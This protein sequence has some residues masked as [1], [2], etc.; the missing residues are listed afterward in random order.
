MS[1]REEILK[2]IMYKDPDLYRKLKRNVNNLNYPFI[3]A[4]HIFKNNVDL[5][6]DIFSF[7][8][9]CEI[10]NKYKQTRLDARH[11]SIPKRSEFY[12]KEAMKKGEFEEKILK[13]NVC[14]YIANQILDNLIYNPLFKNFMT[15][16]IKVKGVEYE[17]EFIFVDTQNFISKMKTYNNNNKDLK[18]L[19]EICDSN[20]KFNDKLEEIAKVL[21]VRYNPQFYKIL[22]TGGSG[23]EIILGD[24]Y[25]IIPIDCR[26]FIGKK[27][28]DYPLSGE[29]DDTVLLMLYDYCRFKYTP[30][31]SIL[32]EDNFGFSL[33]SQDYSEP[34]RR[35]M[36]SHDP[37]NTFSDLFSW[38]IIN[39]EY[40]SLFFGENAKLTML[41]E[42]L[43][44]K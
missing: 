1:T 5:D 30:K 36:F 13:F 35:A 44:V 14:V 21:T 26:D 37:Q 6:I 9:S 22:F 40:P 31:I 24:R 38:D 15:S 4:Y 33:I 32:S 34:I 28:K 8:A 27:C 3:T 16:K 10:F 42:E 43:E 2:N 7:L 39:D 12:I 29:V 17:N 11:S 18:Y 23:D 25:I 19:K 41:E 20:K